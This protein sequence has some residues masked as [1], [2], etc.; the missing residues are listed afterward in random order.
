M[1]RPRCQPEA[2][3]GQ[4]RVAS[5]AEGCVLHLDHGWY[6]FKQPDALSCNGWGAVAIGPVET[7]GKARGDC[8][9]ICD[10]CMVACPY[11]GLIVP[12]SE[13]VTVNGCG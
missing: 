5:V 10:E 8:Y 1:E 3:G 12:V 11:L 13:D 4:D 6:L 2:D 9:N 7:L